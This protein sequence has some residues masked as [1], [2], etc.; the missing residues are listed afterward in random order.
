LLPWC[1]GLGVAGV[2][3]SA[4]AL[5]EPSS[6]HS[7]LLRLSLL[8]TLWSLM[9]FSFIRLFQEIPPP[10]LPKD[11]FLE[12]LRARVKLGLYQLLALGVVVLGVVL[13]GASLKLLN[14]I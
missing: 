11:R 14:S 7:A 9:L 3:L 6:P 4:Y 10:V 1:L 8:L 12:R 5:I 2:G 13:L